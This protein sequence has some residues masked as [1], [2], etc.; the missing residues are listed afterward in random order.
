V[1]ADDGHTYYDFDPANRLSVIR[2]PFGGSFYFEYDPAGRLVSKQLASGAVT[3]QGYDEASRVSQVLHAKSDNSVLASYDYTRDS[4]GNPTR[5]TDENGDYREFQYDS[6]S[7][8]IAEK[9]YDVN[10]TLLDRKV[11]FYDATYS[12]IREDF[13]GGPTVYYL[14]DA[15]NAPTEIRDTDGNVT[16]LEYNAA[17]SLTSET[18]DA[19]TAYYEWNAE[20]MLQRVDLAAGGSAYYDYDGDARRWSKQDSEGVKRY[21]WD[22]TRGGEP[23]LAVVQEVDGGGTTI[24]SGVGSQ[25]ITVSVDRSSLLSGIHTDDIIFE[26]VTSDGVASEALSVRVDA[27]NGTGNMPPM[28]S[29]G[30]TPSWGVA[31]LD[32]SFAVSAWDPDGAIVSWALDFGDGTSDQATGD[33]PA[34]IAH[35]YEAPGT[36]E[37]TVTVTDGDGASASDT[38]TI[39]VIDPDHPFP[40]ANLDATVLSGVAPLDVTYALWASASDSSIVSWALDF[41]D[42]TSEQGSGAPPSSVTHT[43]ETPG[44]YSA[45][46]TVTHEVGAAGSDTVSIAVYAAGVAPTEL[47]PVG[48]TVVVWAESEAGP[49]TGDITATSD[50]RAEQITASLTEVSATRSEAEL[51]LPPLQLAAGAAELVDETWA[52]SLDAT[53]PA[54]QPIQAEFVVRVVAPGEGPPP[55]P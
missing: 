50:L 18:T 47:G 17:G 11:Y 4:R 1:D 19:G 41:G 54:G 13:E 31:P 26:F 44:V 29:L 39:S 22:A 27:G 48:G 34:T 35:T 52:L 43:Y 37:A 3:Y 6:L 20:E 7:R 30:V 2:D 33:P 15:R 25:T 40:V 46:L 16:Y 24:G 14:Y 9:W 5:I 38:V 21:H 36:H 10:D 23:G 42:G 28:A 51:A 8:L 49:P 45:A 32:V 55:V 12:R 53:D